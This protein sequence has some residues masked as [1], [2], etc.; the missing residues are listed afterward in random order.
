[1]LFNFC[2]VNLY[3]IKS[4]VRLQEIFDFSFLA[5]Q[6]PFW[7]FDFYP[8]PFS[9]IKSNSLRY[10][11]LKI[12]PHIIRIHKQNARRGKKH[13]YL[14]YLIRHCSILW[15]PVWKKCCCFFQMD[16][17]KIWQSYGKRLVASSHFLGM[18]FQA[19][20]E[21]MLSVPYHGG[22]RMK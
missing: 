8:R 13:L 17:S 2:A 6:A 7:S 3:V 22:G 20:G 1:M 10:S 14:N 4:T 11:N 5:S 18:V 19:M 15:L 12:I 16:G 21:M 9:N